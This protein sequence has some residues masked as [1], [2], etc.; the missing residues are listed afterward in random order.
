MLSAMESSVYGTDKEGSNKADLHKFQAKFY[1][2]FTT[3]IAETPASGYSNC[4]SGGVRDQ[5]YSRG[6]SNARDFV[7]DRGKVR[8]RHEMVAR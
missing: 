5:A 8:S 4:L 7:G 1:L 6:F 2:D 3:P